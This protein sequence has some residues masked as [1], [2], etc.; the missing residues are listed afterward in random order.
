M[1]KVVDICSGVSRSLLDTSVHDIH[2]ADIVCHFTEW[3][4]IAPY[5]DIT[6]TEE[7][8]IREQYPARPKLQRREALRLWKR[9][10]GSKATYRKLITVF[11]GMQ[12][13]DVAEKIRDLASQSSTVGVDYILDA[14]Y[15]Y[16]I[17]CYTDFPHPSSSQW[18]FSSFRG[19]VNLEL[20]NTPIH[21]SQSTTENKSL[22]PS[23]K[24]ID[25]HS[26]LYAGNSKAKRKVVLM[27]GVAGSGK[28]T[29]FWYACNQWAQGNLFQDFKLLIH[30][31]FSESEFRSASKLADLIP[32]PDEQLRVSV[33]KAIADVRGKGICFLLDACDEAPDPLRRSFL[34]SFIA[35]KGKN[36]L[37]NISIVLASRSGVLDNY[38]GFLSGKV[39]VKGFT[40]ESLSEFIRQNFQDN[41]TGRDQLTEALEMKPELHSLCCYPLNAVIL[42]YLFDVFKDNLPTTQTGLFHPLVCNFLVRH[43]H[44]RE[45]KDINDVP[46]LERLPDDLPLK[47]AQSFNKITKI[48]YKTLLENKKIDQQVLAKY[49]INPSEDDMF[50][51]LQ[52]RP[53][54][55]TMYGPKHQYSFLHLSIQEYL[56]AVFIS[57]LK[58]HMQRQAIEEIYRQDP[59][60]PV[61]SFYSGMTNLQ[62][63]DVQDVLFRVL[64]RDLNS[65]SVLRELV[66]IR[67]PAMDT[68][69]QLLALTN[70]LYECQNRGLCI[71]VIQMLSED[72]KASITTRF[73]QEAFQVGS[74]FIARH[75]DIPDVNFTL[76]FLHMVLH[77]TDVLSIGNFAR[78]VCE[79]L[80][81][82]SVVYLDL[83]Y[84]NI[85][86]VEFKALANELHK[87]VELSKIMLRIN[88]VAQTS[89]SSLII[90]K[91]IQGQSSI[92]GLMME[93]TKFVNQDVVFA[94]KCVIEGLS[95]NSACVTLSLSGWHLN[96]SH[97]HHL[98]LLLRCT[99]ITTLI[100]SKNNLRNGIP[101]LS[102]ALLLTKQLFVLDLAMCNID[103]KALM[104]LG[105]ILNG[106][107]CPLFH[108]SIE[109][110]PY[111]E[112]GLAEFFT[113]IFITTITLLGARLTTPLQKI[114]LQRI[115]DFRREHNLPTLEVRPYHLSD[116]LTVEMREGVQLTRH[117]E[118]N[119]QLSV[120]SR[121]NVPE[122]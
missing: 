58:N 88:H 11:C 2:I 37:P 86:D 43:M 26:L 9:K 67:N 14:F 12:R 72:T 109:F 63:S 47:L 94:L 77:P 55:M 70:C 45:S 62:N 33:A 73:S 49:G 98:V 108:L 51:L 20:C 105:Q 18:P 100:L 57:G 1:A 23:E 27:E 69:R 61:I 104:T 107:I 34:G 71:R 68:R 4:L 24:P 50:G 60:S 48:A 116:S 13:L 95:Y 5:L 120:R 82:R 16:L 80:S 53:I 102:H 3:E 21:E 66:N 106:K 39:V 83:S 25:L 35:G 6:E 75:I 38:K 56:A 15:R 78:I 46:S 96:S 41:P 44:T 30:V 29:L 40:P 89:R 54:N 17:D 112:N 121:Y 122:N 99:D 81:E 10:N 8:D 90:R 28:S 31:S 91:L 118:N 119:P 59:L 64:S 101:L 36:M 22:N 92:A 97:I 87:E 42:T 32:H 85:G 7:A 93:N 74:R 117:M 76:P 103:D 84:C 113:Y 111:T 19:Y 115:N 110:N 114:C 65:T 79:K 52:I